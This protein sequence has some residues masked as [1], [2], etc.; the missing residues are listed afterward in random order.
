MNI[1]FSSETLLTKN[2]ED[3]LLYMKT[4]FTLK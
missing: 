4:T 1:T 2:G 3:W